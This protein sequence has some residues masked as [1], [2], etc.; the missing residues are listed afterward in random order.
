MYASN[1]AI[2][3][4]D[5]SPLHTLSDFEPGELEHALKHLARKKCADKHG[6]VLEMLLHAN[7]TLRAILLTILNHVLH[8]GDLP[9]DWR[10]LL[11]I[12]LPKSGDLLDVKN[13]RPIAILDV[14]YKVFAKMLHSRLEP[15]LEK[16][17]SNEQMGFR[18]MRGCDGALLVLESV[19]AKSFEFQ[20][21]VWLKF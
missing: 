3:V 18:T 17:Q 16:E 6:V 11:F 7:E 10:E 15:V 1:E 14:T 19:I 12:L 4:P 13:W 2:L 20:F 21:P 9:S 5:T 8:T